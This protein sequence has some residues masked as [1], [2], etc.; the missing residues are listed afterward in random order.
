MEELLGFI[1]H[2]NNKECPAS[3]IKKNVTDLVCT[4]QK[5]GP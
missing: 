3:L 2:E 4:I 5:K 1:L